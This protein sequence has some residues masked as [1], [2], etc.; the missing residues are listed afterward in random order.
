M[1]QFNKYLRLENFTLLDGLVRNGLING[2][3]VFPAVKDASNQL[4]IRKT[5]LLSRKASAV[6]ADSFSPVKMMDTG[7]SLKPPAKVAGAAFEP[8]PPRQPVNPT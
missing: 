4:S 1:I 6:A 8:A 7:F 5:Q 3:K 2:I